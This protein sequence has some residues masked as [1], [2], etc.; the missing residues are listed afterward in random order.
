MSMSVVS[1]VRRAG[2]RSRWVRQLGPEWRAL[3]IDVYPWLG[4]G[5]ALGSGGAGQ[6][7]G[8]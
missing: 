6:E 1:R 2:W 3:G 5:S 7:G 8:L 4:C